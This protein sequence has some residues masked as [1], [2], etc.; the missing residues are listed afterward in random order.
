MGMQ[1]AS[2]PFF[3]FGVHLTSIS[4]WD[5]YRWGPLTSPNKVPSR[6]DQAGYF[7]RLAAGLMTTH[8]ESKWALR[9]SQMDEESSQKSF[10]HPLS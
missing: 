8:L 4:E 5:D 10:L 2:P 3:S 7:Y 1:V 6:I 9:S